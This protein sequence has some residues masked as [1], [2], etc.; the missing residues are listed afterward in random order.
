MSRVGQIYQMYNKDIYFVITK[1]DLV[2]R[3]AYIIYQDGKTD[4]LGRGWIERCDLIAEYPTWRE[5]VNSE[6][7]QCGQSMTGTE[8]QKK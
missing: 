3:R 5:A 6:H 4:Y 7:F 8:E 1:M 2:Y